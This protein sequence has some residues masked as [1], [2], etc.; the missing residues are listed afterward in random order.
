MVSNN[1]DFLGSVRGRLQFLYHGLVF[2]LGR[3]E[4]MLALIPLDAYVPLLTG[5]LDDFDR[6][7]MLDH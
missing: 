6:C 4:D 5:Q 2:F 7:F 3:V 1:C